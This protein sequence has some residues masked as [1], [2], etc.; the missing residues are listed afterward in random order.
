MKQIKTDAIQKVQEMIDWLSGK[1]FFLPPKKKRGLE[2]ENKAEKVLKYFIRKRWKF[3]G[4]GKIDGRGKILK[5]TKS[6]HL[7]GDDLAGVDFEILFETGEVLPL[8]IKNHWTWKEEKEYRKKGICLI[9]IWP[10]EDVKKAEKRVYKALQL[11]LFQADLE[12]RIL[13]LEEK[14]LEYS[15]LKK[16]QKIFKKNGNGKEE[17]KKN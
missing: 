12:K 17:K 11:Y 16:F 3:Y 8:Q 4:Q 15:F 6:S 13:K 1:T 14:E 2:A 7:S 9:G 5:I 10:D